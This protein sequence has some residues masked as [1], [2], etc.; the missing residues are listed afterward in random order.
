MRMRWNLSHTS[1]PRLLHWCREKGWSRGLEAC[2]I[3][4]VAW[5]VAQGFWWLAAP[6]TTAMDV[7]ALPTLSVQNQHTVA[8]HFF[9]V[10]ST[11]QL[12]DAPDE[13]PPPQSMDA[14]WRLTGTYVGSGGHS[15][16]VLALE[17]GADVVVAKV[18]DQLSTGHEVV[19]VR[20]DSVVLSKDALRGEL[21]LRP[22]ASDAQDQGQPVDRFGTAEPAPFNKDSR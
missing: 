13:S 5:I 2:A 20:P 8:R 4:A 22:V 16:A 14:R 1:L 19:E 17:G 6:S 15:R 7:K 9:G 11:S 10:V 18:G 21:A 12:A 3:A